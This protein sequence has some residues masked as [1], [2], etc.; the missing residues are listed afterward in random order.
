MKVNYVS[1][2]KEYVRKS[3]NERFVI[4]ASMDAIP[5]LLWFKQ[6]QLFWISSPRLVKLCPEPKLEQNEI[7]VSILNQEDI[8]EAIN[9]LIGLITRITIFPT[10]IIQDNPASLLSFKEQII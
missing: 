1:V 6:L 9:S 3:K 8:L 10:S 2:I 4:K 7:F 5:P